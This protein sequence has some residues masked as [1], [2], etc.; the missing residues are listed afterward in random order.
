MYEAAEQNI[1]G[2]IGSDEIKSVARHIKD[3]QK[4]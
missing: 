1:T 2:L 3:S 4:H